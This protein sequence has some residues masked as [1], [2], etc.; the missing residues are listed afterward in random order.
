MHLNCISSVYYFINYIAYINYL[1]CLML[2]EIFLFF[3]FV[4]I[5][6]I[7]QYSVN[8]DIADHK[9]KDRRAAIAAIVEKF[10]PDIRPFLHK[11]NLFTSTRP[12][13]L[14]WL[15]QRDIKTVFGLGELI[16]DDNAEF[17]CGGGAAVAP[18]ELCCN[19]SA[20]ATGDRLVF[21][22]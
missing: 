8:L 4:L 17:N 16:V 6:L 12:I 2:V 3:V 9:W 21:F 14:G 19:R 11:V 5:F 7:I 18:L 1:W 13:Q 10:G 22:V 20:A 15:T